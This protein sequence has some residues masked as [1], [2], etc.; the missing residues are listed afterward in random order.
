MQNKG[1]LKLCKNKED[2][3]GMIMTSFVESFQDPQSVT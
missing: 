2:R 3:N 1:R